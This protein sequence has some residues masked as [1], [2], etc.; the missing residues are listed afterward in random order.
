VVPAE[1]WKV[2]MIEGHITRMLFTKA[3]YPDNTCR[4]NRGISP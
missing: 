1:R 4:A 2:E 3:I